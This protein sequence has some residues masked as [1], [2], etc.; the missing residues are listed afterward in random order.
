MGWG[1]H[2]RAAPTAHKYDGCV[3][4]YLRVCPI[5]NGIVA[6]HSFLQYQ[7]VRDNYK[8]CLFFRL[9]NRSTI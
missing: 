9:E 7:S 6:K 5:G 3:G 8:D 4:V 2:A 1:E